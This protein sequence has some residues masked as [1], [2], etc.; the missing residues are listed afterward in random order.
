MHRS[1]IL[2]LLSSQSL[3]ESE[4]S[5]VLDDPVDGA[6]IHLLQLLAGSF[7][8]KATAKVIL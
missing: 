6:V 5:V 1:A 7:L 8:D 4:Q 3:L 2:F